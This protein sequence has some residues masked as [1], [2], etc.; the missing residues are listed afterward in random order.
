MDKRGLGVFLI[1]GMLILL[2]FG[3]R[4]YRLE[5]KNLWQD[6]GL[7]AYRASQSLPFILSNTIFIQGY[8]THDTQPPLYFILLHLVFRLAGR[9][10]F[11]GRF[12]SLLFTVLV[13]PLTYLTGKRL[14]SQA[15]GIWASSLAALSPLYLW[16]AQELRMY[17][18]L[19]FLGLLSFYAMLRALGVGEGSPEINR[20]WLGFYI[21]VA[22]AMVYTHYTGFFLLFFEALI[23]LAVGLL[24]RQW[25][26]LFLLALVLLVVLPLLPF[27]IHR[28][29]TPTEERGYRF[30][31][32]FIILRDLWNSFSLGISVSMKE[33]WWLDLF[34]L[35]L[36]LL[37]C[38]MLDQGDP[39]AR[40]GKSLFLLGYLF[41]P[42]MTLYSLS[43][44][45]PMYLGVRHLIIVSPAYYLGLGVGLDSLKRRALPLLPPVAILL[46]GGLFYS[47]YN[48]YFDERYMKDDFRSM[49]RYIEEHSRP[50]DLV[51]FNDAV[52]SHIWEYY[53]RGDL[54]WTALPQYPESAGPSTVKEMERLV[55][56]Y[57]GI[58]LVYGPENPLQDR[59][60]LVK[61]WFEEHLFK[62]DDRL[63]P[64]T[65]TL[66]AVAYHLPHSPI[67]E[68]LPP[69]GEE[70]GANLGDRLLLLGYERGWPEVGHK[71]YLTLFWR[72]KEA[73]A[74]DYSFSFRLMDQE[75]QPWGQNDVIPFN[76]LYPTSRWEPHKVI[77]QPVVIP[78]PPG[79]PPG[80]YQ[81]SLRVYSRRDGQELEVLDE[82]GVPAGTA[83]ALG[84]FRLFPS[85][86]PNPQALSFPHLRREEFGGQLRLLGYEL[87]S[88]EWR[89]GES[90]HL[91]LHW[92]AMASLTK[93]YEVVLQMVDERGEVLQERVYHPSKADYPTSRWAVGSLVRG[94]YDVLIPAAAEGEK[95]RLVLK[96]REEKRE[97]FLPLGPNWWPIKGYG[98][99]LAK[100]TVS[101]QERTFQ[102]PSVQHPMRADLGGKVEFLGYDLDKS[103]VERGESITLI[104]YWR[105]LTEME[106]N[107]H[108]FV[109]LLSEE[110]ETWAQKDSPPVEGSRPTAGWVKG[111][112][113]RDEYQ[114]A[115]EGEIPAGEYLLTAGIYKPVSG[116]GLPVLI[117]GERI[118]G[119]RI[120]LGILRVE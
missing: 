76:D 101:E 32:L 79:T 65:T 78:L 72:V 26:L 69:M 62:A 112:V 34:F 43:H 114:I 109:H 86:L 52:I 66:L 110:G 21:P 24:H 42:I 18:L 119:D 85:P 80:L 120:T 105:A 92:Q 67:L 39:R 2:A 61:T 59:S 118:Q 73:L 50:G 55:E 84:E 22:G 64:A 87:P 49:V 60:G 41:V 12:L 81:L 104:L 103:Q 7:S 47:T 115:L 27:T 19:V 111:E 48:C 17:S 28:L 90:L 38:F 94:Q 35:A 53:A 25:T 74:E 9:S 91:E 11:S 10:E 37:G 117:E 23:F 68:S 13:V 51:V 33:V 29:L 107:Y 6:E 100:L 15:A 57:E 88:K 16:Y 36:F 30:V 71:V 102:L 97:G 1:L 56:A 96:V 4:L 95:V 45:K 116:E 99:A 58:W 3:L 46:L 113:I 20:R 54:D 93:N 82:R 89:S 5:A 75:G 83:V 77:A 106:I 40:L 31:P 14:L 70:V 98:L 108:V 8:P 44:I 63:F